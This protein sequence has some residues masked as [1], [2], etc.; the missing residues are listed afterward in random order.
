MLKTKNKQKREGKVNTRTSL[1]ENNT[2]VKESIPGNVGIWQSRDLSMQGQLLHL[3]A[4]IA[5]RVQRRGDNEVHYDLPQACT[6]EM[7]W[8]GL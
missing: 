7:R 6:V 4:F 3:R 2:L 1:N 8:S 5:I